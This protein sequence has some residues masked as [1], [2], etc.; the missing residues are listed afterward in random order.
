MLTDTA[1][2]RAKASEKPYKL[3]DSQ[4]L[5]LYVTPTGYKSWRWKYRFAGKEKRLVFGAYPGLTLAEARGMREDAAGE[6][7]A[8][9][10]PSVQK[11]Q[12]FAAHLA[13]AGSTFETVANDWYASQ[14]RTWSPR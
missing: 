13:R 8:G 9:I 12:R 1:C 4:G 6:V 10:D 14:E 5:H 11:R 3:A 2:K 7:R